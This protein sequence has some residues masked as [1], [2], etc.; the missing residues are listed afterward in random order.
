MA[1][2]EATLRLKE[3]D[4]AE[5]VV[6][7]ARSKG[8]QPMALAK[9]TFSAADLTATLPLVPPRSNDEDELLGD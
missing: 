2:A 8:Y 5:A 3:K 6:L 9:A 4:I 1:Y 7:W